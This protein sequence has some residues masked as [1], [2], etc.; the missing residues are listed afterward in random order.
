[1]QRLSDNQT[2]TITAGPAFISKWLAPRLYEF[3]Q[4][5]PEI[6]LQFSGSLRITDFDRDAVDVAIRF[7]WGHDKDVY[8]EPLIREW[9]TPMMTPDL[10]EQYGTLEKLA[11]VPLI[12]DESIAFFKQ[13]TD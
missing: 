8:S 5:H 10:A 1:M 2:L 4:A 9:M 6:E 11:H 3:A 12:H 7:G 13:P